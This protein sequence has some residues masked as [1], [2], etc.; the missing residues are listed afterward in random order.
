MYSN[1]KIKS[2]WFAAMFGCGLMLL[3]LRTA[4]AQQPL[5]PELILEVE[6][7]QE[8]NAQPN[9]VMAQPPAPIAIPFRSTTGENAYA[10]AKQTCERRLCSWRYQAVSAGAVGLGP[11]SD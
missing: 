9:F 11:S 6:A 8:V 2:Y 1:S 7:A 3:T 10:A 4:S 5:R